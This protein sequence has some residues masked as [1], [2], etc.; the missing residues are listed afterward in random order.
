MNKLIL[1]MLL[2]FAGVVNAQ[3]S[4]LP[5]EAIRRCAVVQADNFPL[6]CKASVDNEGYPNFSCLGSRSIV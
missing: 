5:V 2:L 6:A 4:P 1:V 3:Q